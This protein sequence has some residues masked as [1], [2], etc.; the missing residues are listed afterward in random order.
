MGYE[1]ESMKRRDNGNGNGK[2]KGKGKWVGVGIERC[3]LNSSTTQQTE[4]EVGELFNIVLS[5][6]R[7]K[8]REN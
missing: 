3:S 2:G 8:K 7:Y 6:R 5:K 4:E 1:N